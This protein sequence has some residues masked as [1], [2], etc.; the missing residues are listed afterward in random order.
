MSDT[1]YSVTLNLKGYEAKQTPVLW[2]EI[3]YFFGKNKHSELN[4][5]I[6]IKFCF[7]KVISAPPPMDTMIFD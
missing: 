7:M 4:I 3:F 5:K 2:A 1:K 6:S